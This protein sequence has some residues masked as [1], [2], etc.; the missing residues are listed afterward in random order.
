MDV[1]RGIHAVIGGG[2]RHGAQQAEFFVMADHFDRYAAGGR[3]GADVYEAGLEGVGVF[4]RD[5]HGV[6]PAR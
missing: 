2:A 4:K 6:I 5:G 1:L 3:G